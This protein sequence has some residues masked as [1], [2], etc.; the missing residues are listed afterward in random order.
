MKLKLTLILLVLNGYLQAQMP[1]APSKHNLEKRVSL[2]VKNTRVSEVLNKVS[3]A[4]EF[5]FSYSGALFKQDSLVNLDVRNAPVREILDKLFNNKVDYKENGDYVILRYAAKHL[6]IEPE[7][8]TSAEKLYLISGYVIDTE[9]GQKVKQASVYEKRLLQSTL[10]DQDGF[11]KL[12]FKGEHTEVILTASKENYRD[13]TLIFLS[14][15][16]VKP[17]GYQDP[18]SAAASGVFSD[19]ESSGIGRFFISSRQRIQSLNIP[20]FFANSPFQ[21]SL[22]PGL[23]SHGI[24]SSQV[25]NKF[26]LNV[27]GGYTAGT[28][29]FEIAGLFNITKGDVKKLQFAGLFNEAGGSLNGFQVAGLLNNVRG[30]KQGFQ[31]AGLLNRVK[32]NT[33]GFQLAGLCNLSYK[34]MMGAQAAGILNLV[35]GNADGV[36]IAGIANLLRKDMDGTQIAGVGNMTRHLKGVQIAGVFNYAKRMDGFQVG[37]INV[38]DTSSGYSLGLINIVKQGYHKISL[39]ANETVNTNIAVKTG[40]SKLYTILFAGLNLSKNE[41]VGTAGLGLGHD[42]L[43]TKRLS[44]GLETTGQLLYL[45]NWDGANLLSKLQ[46][47]MQVQVFKGITLFAGPAYSVYSSE[48]PA[49]SSSAGY[50]QNV[51]PKHHTSF[52]SSTKG[53]LGFNAGITFM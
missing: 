34:D 17:E 48:N 5:Y 8:I 45:G 27:F 40:N 49:N 35:A 46:A 15:I 31:A 21:T 18:N 41:K 24:M 10:S 44:I 11:F 6:T 28:N 53:W 37:L 14:D 36:Q 2:A 9:T 1:L 38:S 23:S 3:R 12:R 33:A 52:G 19:V 16:K 42:F 13:T 30:E 4:G 22:T 39:F 7:N 20:S 26:S 47:N 25:V 43:I 29:G 50:K 32:G 51:V